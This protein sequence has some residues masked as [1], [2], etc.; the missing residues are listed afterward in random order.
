MRFRWAADHTVSATALIRWME[1]KIEWVEDSYLVDDNGVVR[2]TDTDMNLN[3]EAVDSFRVAVAS[4]S[5]P[6][7]IMISVFETREATGIFEGTVQFGTSTA[8]GM[9]KVTDGDTVN[10]KYSDHTRDVTTV[11]TD[12]TLVLK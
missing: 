12:G 4:P 3:P 7:G 8:P 2:V 5:D 10:A 6:V 11:V 9:I 1:G